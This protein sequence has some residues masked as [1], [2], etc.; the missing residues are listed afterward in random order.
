MFFG[1]EW[2]VSS[3]LVW[4]WFRLNLFNYIC[5]KLLKGEIMNIFLLKCFKFIFF[6]KNVLDCDESICLL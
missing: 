6:L 1:L 4:K 5:L 3:G 2:N